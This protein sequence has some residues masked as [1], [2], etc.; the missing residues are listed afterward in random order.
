MDDQR[1][2][3][4][5]ESTQD[6]PSSLVL[7]DTGKFVGGVPVQTSLRLSRH[8]DSFGIQPLR[9]ER[10]V[11]NPSPAESLAPFY[12]DP[13]Q[14]IIVLE[15]QSYLVLRVGLLLEILESRGG[16]EVG[17]DEW[18]RHV[19]TPSTSHIQESHQVALTAE[20]WVSGCRLFFSYPV[21]PGQDFQMEV[22]DFS[23]L[24]REKY[25]SDRV[26]EELGGIGCLL[27]T[28]AKA[29]VPSGVFAGTHSIHDSLIFPRVSIIAFHYRWGQG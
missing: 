18:K 10:G 7:M 20:V 27:P 17:W 13:A 5:L 8:F 1:L 12:N 9:L 28:G 14:R 3:V 2:L 29:Q 15:T 6:A 26:D 11:H 24:R 21:G 22:Y 19:F 16:S 25:L 4:S 23:V